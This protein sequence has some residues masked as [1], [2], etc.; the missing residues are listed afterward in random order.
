MRGKNIS[1]R[2]PPFSRAG[3]LLRGLLP[4]LGLCGLLPLA[5]ASAQPDALERALASEQQTSAAVELD[6]RELFRVSGTAIMPAEKRAAAINKR[7]L[8]VASNPAIAP[9]SLQIVDEPDLTRIVA[10]DTTIIALAD[11]D[12]GG[13]PRH[14]IAELGLRQMVE[15]IEEY[16]EVRTPRV[17]LERTAHAI[18]ATLVAGALLGRGLVVSAVA[19]AA[20]RSMLVTSVSVCTSI[21][22]RS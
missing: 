10:G 9:E 11:L 13:L 6:G 4:A 17:L 14:R 19:P 2:R 15:R 16:R 18:A 12:T 5:H 8:A 1:C 3:M 21:L 20:L 7:L 22:K